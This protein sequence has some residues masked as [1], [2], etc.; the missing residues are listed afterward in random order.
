MVARG[1][2][3][4]VT[5][6][7]GHA[8]RFAYDALGRLARLE[9]PAGPAVSFSNNVLGHLTGIDLPGPA[10][11]RRVCFEP[12]ALGRVRRVAYPDGSEERFAYDP[13]GNVTNHVDAAGRVTTLS[14][15][16]TGKLASVTRT[17]AGQPLTTCFDHD[18]QFNV[19]EIRNPRGAAVESYR[20]DALDRVVGVTNLEGQAMT[21][22]HAP[23]NRVRRVE[24]FDGTTVRSR[25]DGGG[26][27]AFV[28]YP[29]VESHFAYAPDGMLTFATNEAGT[30]T[31]AY[32]RANRVTDICGVAPGGTVTYGY[33][34]AGQVTG[35]VS[36][37]GAARVAY[38]AAGRVTRIAGED[39]EA[40]GYGYEP[41]GGLVGGLTN[42]TVGLT[43]EYGYDVMNRVT[44][45]VWRSAGGE[46]PRSFRYTYNA[47]GLVARVAR[48][49]G[50]RIDYAY[51]ELDRLTGETHRNAAG[52][53]TSAETWTYDATGNRLS[54]AHAGL[55]AQ[56]RHTYADQGDRLSGWTTTAGGGDGVCATVLALGNE[57]CPGALVDLGLGEG[58]SGPPRGT[59]F[60]FGGGGMAVGGAAPAADGVSLLGVDGEML[61][62]TNA[63]YD[64]ITNATYTH[65]AAGCVTQI[66]YN[67]RRPV[68][69]GGVVVGA[70]DG[71]FRNGTYEGYAWAGEDCRGY[72][73][74]LPE[75]ANG[76]TAY[77]LVRTLD[78]ADDVSPINMWWDPTAGES[79][80]YVIGRLDNGVMYNE[81]YLAWGGASGD[82]L[83][84]EWSLLRDTGGW[85]APIDTQSA[86][87][88]RRWWPNV[89]GEAADA[90]AWTN[91]AQTVAFEWNG[92][93]QLTG[94]Q[95]GGEAVES[96]TYDALG[97]R[98]SMTAGGETTYMVY[99]GW[100]VIADVDAAG[101]LKRSY[102]HGPGIDNLLAMTVYEGEEATTYYYLTDRLGSVHAI[103]DETGTVVEQY[104]YDAWGRPTVFDGDGHLRS[105]SAIGN[106]YL[107][108]GRAYSWQT[109]LYHHRHRYYNPLTGRWLSKDP[110]GIAGGLNQYVA[111][112][113]NP[114]NARDPMGLATRHGGGLL[115]KLQEVGDI[116]EVEV[117]FGLQGK[118]KA[119]FV[120]A[121][122]DFGTE[123][124]RFKGCRL[125]D[126]TTMGEEIC[127]GIKN[128]LGAQLKR[129][130]KR[131]GHAEKP[132]DHPL[133]HQRLAG[134]TPREYLDGSPEQWAC[135]GYI[136]G[137]GKKTGG[138]IKLEAGAALGWGIEGAINLSE[139]WDFLESFR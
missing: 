69:N 26:R 66:V 124:T 5:N 71:S 92:R 21:V 97:R 132:V 56:S 42:A 125:H 11:T 25:H 3:T 13:A 87:A 62:F 106:R 34:P 24:R 84:G 23:G 49:S 137:I 110:I 118:V 99:D 72:Y 83:S 4:A 77:R 98:V 52:R 65:N 16:P 119:G 104:R 89:A 96:Y 29:D 36:V 6:A 121:G 100:H 126:S 94:V 131:C 129:Y 41:Y 107:W 122:L 57:A 101:A 115:G 55:D 2:V 17:V 40:F 93:Y 47:A 20:L 114:V 127:V 79:G 59:L 113:N 85:Y 32:D 80:A 133:T 135:G 90:I 128:L 61:C 120:T 130:R 86:A 108:Q 64:A 27:L 102:T 81:Y 15:R 109:H 9:P 95:V 28:G 103:V 33:D 134:Q 139:A 138:D 37:A 10:G 112:G 14:W 73:E 19:V 70:V 31:Y 82:P 43:A 53:L 7:N 91:T 1:L 76:K 39:G 22:Y 60:L 111:F 30:V 74:P 46:V 45:I 78:G 51:D 116:F 38:D 35:R 8:V 18:R 68:H 63:A 117:S 136:L 44:N 48:E 105:R 67:G 54:R 123:R 50:E 58:D 12:D 75:I 88:L